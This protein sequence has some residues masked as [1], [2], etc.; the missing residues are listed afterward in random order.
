MPS[1]FGCAIA[2]VAGC[3]LH[4]ALAQLA[5]FPSAKSAQYTFAASSAIP[6]GLCS[7]IASTVGCAQPARAQLKMLPAGDC[8]FVKKTVDESTATPVAPNVPAVSGFWPP[9]EG[10]V[11]V[12]IAPDVIVVL[13]AQ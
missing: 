4:P 10:A 5:I 2:I 8:P 1:G 6:I 9:H 3:M 12:L 13:S 11:H 7:L